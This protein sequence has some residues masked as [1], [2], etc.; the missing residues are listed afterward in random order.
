VTSPPTVSPAA[1]A[2]AAVAAAGPPVLV[3]LG[4][5]ASGKEGA[6]VVAAPLLGA[7][8]VCADSVKP[9]RGLAIAAAAPPAA[10]LALVRHHLVGV[11]DPSERL[12]AR[13]W[14]GLVEEAVAELRSRGA[15]PL[16][17]GG[18]ALYLRALLF[19]LFEGPEGDPE[20]R[21]R[22]RADEAACPGTLHA[23]LAAVDPVAAARL[24]PNDLKRLLR[25]LEVHEK[26]GRPISELQAQ[27]SGPPR[28][29]YLAVGLRRDRADLRARIDRRV[30]RM[31]AEGLVDEV[32]AVAAPGRL[33]PT[34]SEAIGVKELLPTLRRELETG[35]RDE[36]AL[37]AAVAE[38]KRN[39]WTFARR[40]E[41]WWR[42]FPGV[43]WLDVPASEAPA[44]TGR[45]I[46]SHFGSALA[47]HPA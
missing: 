8:I 4:S 25:A 10:S 22:L 24:H 5:T 45:R 47:S 33:G 14:C 38:V 36:S 27:W 31:V 39:T 9:Y 26:T 43:T 2:A 6:A 12:H 35:T 44:E 23:R 40:Q 46:A 28:I 37:A 42:R 1:V 7:E 19:G 16:I 21:A 3:V 15:R 30:D 29:P 18:T 11:L 41:T 17:V 20:L 34:A 13:R 32:R